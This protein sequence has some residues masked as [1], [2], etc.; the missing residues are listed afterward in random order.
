MNMS[1]AECSDN[2]DN[3][4]YILQ[5]ICLLCQNFSEK[6]K[7]FLTVHYFVAI[8]SPPIL[9]ENKENSDP[10]CHQRVGGGDP[11]MINQDDF[12]HFRVTTNKASNNKNN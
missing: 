9:L 7:Y 5:K 3:I 8:M 2:Q 6:I 1:C 4:F 12:F 10:Y 11:A